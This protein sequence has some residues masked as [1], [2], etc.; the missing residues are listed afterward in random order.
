M[1][2]SNPVAN[3]DR[4]TFSQVL[5]MSQKRAR[6]NLALL[7]TS[8]ASANRLNLESEVAVTD[9]KEER[10][11]VNDF[12]ERNQPPL[13]V[14]KHESLDLGTV[15][16]KRPDIPICG[17]INAKGIPIHPP[18]VSNKKGFVSVQRTFGG[19]KVPRDILSGVAQALG[20]SLKELE[21]SHTY[22]Y[23]TPKGFLHRLEEQMGRKTVS[24][25][26]MH[27]KLVG[28]MLSSR[29]WRKTFTRLLPRKPSEGW[30]TLDSSLLDQLEKL[31][32]TF[33]SS[34]GA[35]YWRSKLEAFADILEVVLPKVV[36]ALKVKGGV[37]RLYREQP[38]LFLVEVKNKLDR[39]EN[40]KLE[41]KTRPY[42]SIP[43]HWSFLF[44][45][46]SQ[47]FCSSLEI[48]DQNKESSNAYGFSGA[49]GGYER[50]WEWMESVKEGEFKKICYGDDTRFVTR[51]GGQLLVCDPDAK[52]MDGSVDFQVVSE[53]VDWQLE[54]LLEEP[55]E[56]NSTARQFWESVAFMWKH[57]A[58]NP[59]MIVDGTSIW[60]KKSR[61]GLMT[62]VTGTT[63]FDTVK[64][65]VS[66]QYFVDYYQGSKFSVKEVSEWMLSNCGIEVK[67]GTWEW[68]PVSNP[69]HLA[70]GQLVCESKFLGV[71]MLKWDCVDGDHT[72][73]PTI[74]Y[75]EMMENL[76]VPK[77]DPI[78]RDVKSVIS[79]QRLVFDRLRGLY[80]T[81]G[82]TNPVFENVVHHLV[83]SLPLVPIMMQTQLEGGMKPEHIT[84]QGVGFPDSSG[85]PSREF[86]E[87]LYS[88]RERPEGSGFISLVS[89]WDK[90]L[91]FARSEA[92]VLKY[93][94]MPTDN[95]HVRDIVVQEL[96]RE[97]EPVL[98]LSKEFDYLG[99]S[100]TQKPSLKVRNPRSK[101]EQPSEP[102]V[103]RK[104]LPDLRESII[105]YLE[106]VGYVCTQDGLRGHF[107][108][109]HT[110]FEREAGKGYFFTCLEEG[111]DLVSLYPILLPIATTQTTLLETMVD[112]PIKAPKTKTDVTVPRLP[113]VRPHSSVKVDPEFMQRLVDTRVSPRV[114]LEPVA[115]LG[116]V[117]AR[118]EMVVTYV[119]TAV[120]A[121]DPLPVKMEMRV[122]SIPPPGKQPV[123]DWV[124]AYVEGVTRKFMLETLA[125]EILALL[126][127]YRKYSELAS[128]HK[129]YDEHPGPGVTRNQDRKDV[130]ALIGEKSSAKGEWAED[131]ETDLLDPI[132]PPFEFRDPDQLPPSVR[133]NALRIRLMTYMK[134]NY[135]GLDFFRVRSDVGR[136]TT[137]LYIGDTHL[138]ALELMAIKELQKIYGKAE[139]L[140][141]KDV[142]SV[143][144]KR[145]LNRKKKLKRRERDRKA[146]V[147]LAPPPVVYDTGS[148]DPPSLIMRGSGETEEIGTSS[149]ALIRSQELF[150]DLQD[151]FFKA[152][153][154]EAE[155]RSYKFTHDSRVVERGLD[156][157]EE[158]VR[159]ILKADRKETGGFDNV[160]QRRLFI[161]R[162]LQGV[163]RL[164][165]EKIPPMFFREGMAAF[166][167]QS[168]PVQGGQKLPP[169]PFLKALQK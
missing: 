34:A 168:A 72:I 14:L 102:N 127:K 115:L 4:R 25:G 32:I 164:M 143:E 110:A 87:V 5:E 136:I 81:F 108:L 23:G 84:L 17:L 106:S 36:E 40:Q 41:K 38:E 26:D 78:T 46:L 128:L 166:K 126:L 124:V 54:A 12:L 45:I 149:N 153:E 73:V 66:W 162:T 10:E 122:A 15:A 158:A 2:T 138:D 151:L 156:I 6:Q 49:H 125:K 21:L 94:L 140:S 48:F 105:L 144:A 132:L 9:K 96:K 59:L 58:T 99:S 51:R 70:H 152:Q 39:Y 29:M 129:Y 112:P 146:K 159:L 135:N 148:S 90:L 147:L 169:N 121:Q 8:L 131:V 119:T 130:L 141:E 163:N 37:D 24:I 101:I 109:S 76:L 74:P 100:V 167:S 71:Q 69:L 75:S 150:E 83:N 65:V 91:D 165:E 123:Y 60:Q 107:G 154:L 18:S 57:M 62:G 31:D 27:K 20:Y 50:M 1:D 42:V 19:A 30:P 7:E 161:V 116:A 28:G 77:D 92:R 11:L 47:R 157:S 142:K 155:A 114:P 89:G 44:S 145:K 53:V 56:I 137:L 68:R 82:F 118:N 22:T 43:A 52:Q 93:Q 79:R 97:E 104:R 111:F 33:S 120:R 86:C 113:V 103:V 134:E 133:L 88:G 98:E 64:S 117:V 85:W 67:D 3:G 160:R 80:L 61:D 139:V 95:L 35:P 63:L 13:M 55:Q 16:L